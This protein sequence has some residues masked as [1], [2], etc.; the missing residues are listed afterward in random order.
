MQ[1]IVSGLTEAKAQRWRALVAYRDGKEGLLCLGSSYAQ[2]QES[3]DD[4]YFNLLDDE[5]RSRVHE[6]RLQK[7]SGTPDSGIW[8]TQRTL[9]IPESLILPLA[10]RNKAI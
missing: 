5:E 4:P 9:E 1:K 6:I 8:E 10:A 7:W 3:Y 2:V